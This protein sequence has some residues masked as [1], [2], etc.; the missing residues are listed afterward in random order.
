MPS[1]DRRIKDG[2]FCTIAFEMVDL[3][4]PVAWLKQTV[5]LEIPINVLTGY[6][7]EHESD[8]SWIEVRSTQERFESM[9][10]VC[11]LLRS[12]V[13]VICHL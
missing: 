2:N 13:V 4:E 7:T 12:R 3:P 9:A 8:R 5:G 1:M 6:A 11:D 10:D